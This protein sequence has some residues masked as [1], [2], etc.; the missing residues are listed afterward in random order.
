MLN[1][2]TVI[3]ILLA[4]ELYRHDDGYASSVV[5]D[6]VHLRHGC[7]LEVLVKDSPPRK[8]DGIENVFCIDPEVFER[9]SVL[10]DRD[11]SHA[12]HV[13]VSHIE[14]RLIANS[15]DIHRM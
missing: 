9:L 3:S 7:P 11:A 1:T 4:F 12:L 14:P 13:R 10:H 8:G 15:H 2:L 5:A 6:D